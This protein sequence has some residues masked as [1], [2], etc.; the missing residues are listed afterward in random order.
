MPEYGDEG[1]FSNH[2]EHV[3]E[4]ADGVLPRLEDRKEQEI[5]ARRREEHELWHV[6]PGANEAHASGQVCERCG[7]VI[8]AKQD[9]RLLPDGR[10]THEVCPETSEGS[11]EG[12]E[13]SVGPARSSAS[14]AEGK[15]RTFFDLV[16]ELE[17]T[18]DAV[19]HVY[20]ATDHLARRP[21][22]ATAEAARALGE[23]LRAASPEVADVFDRWRG[24]CDEFFGVAA[25]L[26]ALRNTG[27]TSRRPDEQRSY[28]TM[29]N[30]CIGR[31][32]A[33]RQELVEATEEL[34]GAVIAELD[35][36]LA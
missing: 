25:D 4:G 30:A 35:R 5:E 16:F 23:T 8:T 36:R 9:A 32:H 20:P 26:N 18:M 19:R 24:L 29:L 10:W 12:R 2:E 11:G 22:R 1:L 31:V 15:G 27:G 33:L 14:A 13:P 17:R 3:E 21:G 28:K 34:Q 7:S 6:E